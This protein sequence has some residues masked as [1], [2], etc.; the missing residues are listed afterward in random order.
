MVNPI[1]IPFLKKEG[2]R[3]ALGS[4]LGS[5]GI[6]MGRELLNF[7]RGIVQ[8]QGDNWPRFNML[9]NSVHTLLDQEYS[10]DIN[11]VPSFRWYNPA[12]LLSHLSEK[13]LIEL[14]EGGEHS[15]YPSVEPI[16][17]CTK[18]SRTMEEILTRFETGDLR[19]DPTEVHRPRSSRRR[20]PP[21]RAALRA[22]AAAPATPA[23][24]K[25]VARKK[26][27]GANK[28]APASR[29]AAGASAE[30]EPGSRRAA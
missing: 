5:L 20:P 4:A 29:K 14:M 8:R 10:G 2:S 30:G 22:Q 16:R 13:D 6:G 11:I 28:K 21:T 19:P 26:T 15:T 1:A 27:A 24:Q 7:Y 25:A 9:M 23:K 3:S 17:I 12:K 18:I